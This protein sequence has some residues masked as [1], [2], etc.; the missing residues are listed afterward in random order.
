MMTKREFNK[1][2]RE[3]KEIGL[4]DNFPTSKW[5]ESQILREIH[6]VMA[7]LTEFLKEKGYRIVEDKWDKMWLNT[8]EAIRENRCVDEDSGW[9]PAYV[10]VEAEWVEGDGGYE[11]LEKDGVIVKA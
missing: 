2:F 8:A 9:S 7:Y 3:N 11:E 10:W 1:Q 6:K 5:L 4:R